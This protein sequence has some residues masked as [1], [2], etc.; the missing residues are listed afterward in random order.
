[1]ISF[2][3]NLAIAMYLIIIAFI[4]VITVL[5]DSIGI[6]SQWRIVR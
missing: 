2:G 3:S 5:T 1:M 4:G 6:A